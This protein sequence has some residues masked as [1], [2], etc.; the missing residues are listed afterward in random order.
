[1]IDLIKDISLHEKKVKTPLIYGPITFVTISSD[2]FFPR[3]F[4]YF[5]SSL[6]CPVIVDI[7]S[8]LRK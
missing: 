1:M 8:S 2:R 5:R 4:K 6:K 3:I 7:C